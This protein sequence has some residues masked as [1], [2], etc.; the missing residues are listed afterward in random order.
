VGVEGEGVA[1]GADGRVRFYS[2]S[3]TFVR[4]HFFGAPLP[5][6]IYMCMCIWIFFENWEGERAAGVVE[7]KLRFSPFPNIIFLI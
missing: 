5:S 3:R 7:R 1:G 6:D 2:F 4:F